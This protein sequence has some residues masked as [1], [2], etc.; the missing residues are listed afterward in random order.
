[1]K[2]L[3]AVFL[4]SCVVVFFVPEFSPRQFLFGVRVPEALRQSGPGRR[5]LLLYRL[6]IAA[7]CVLGLALIQSHFRGGP[8]VPL[9][10]LVAGSNSDNS[11]Q[12]SSSQV[13]RDRCFTEAART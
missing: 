6:S 9:L 12:W 11:R 8:V 5:A 4:L 2:T 1:M 13:V 7:L 10:L 3:L